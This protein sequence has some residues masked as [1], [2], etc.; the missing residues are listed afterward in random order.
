MKGSQ[1]ASDVKDPNL[2]SLKTAA[3]VSVSALV[4]ERDGGGD[5]LWYT[6]CL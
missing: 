6:G 5:V 3:N 1:L 2:R 4:M